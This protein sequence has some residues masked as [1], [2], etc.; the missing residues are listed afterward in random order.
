MATVLQDTLLL[1]VLSRGDL[2]AIEAKYRHN[3]LTMYK[4]KHR[5]KQRASGASDI[6]AFV[7]LVSYIKCCMDGGT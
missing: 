4:N 6:R 5:R 7:E 1:S 3:C 2:T